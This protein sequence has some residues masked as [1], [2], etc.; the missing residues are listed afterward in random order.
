MRYPYIALAVVF[1]FGA[2]SQDPTAPIITPQVEVSRRI[3]LPDPHG[4]TGSCQP[5]LVSADKSGFEAL[6]LARC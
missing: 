3:P 2:C 4:D 1:L 6:R 5:P